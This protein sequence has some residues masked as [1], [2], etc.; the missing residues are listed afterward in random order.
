MTLK[1]II[2]FIIASICEMAGGFFIWLWIREGKSIWFGLIG[3]FILMLYGVVATFQPAN[4]ARTYATYGGFFIVFSLVWAYI[5][6][7]FK[8][9]KFDLIV[10]FVALV[11][12]LIIY[13]SPR[14]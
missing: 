3:G 13:L 9:T 7:N 8:P 14:Q 10:A 5:F 2:I 12:V 1:T 6:D 11:G 4:F